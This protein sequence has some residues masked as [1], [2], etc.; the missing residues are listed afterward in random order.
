MSDI[1]DYLNW[2]EAA[3][4][5]TS[6]GIFEDSLKAAGDQSQ[7]PRRKDPLSLYLDAVELE[8]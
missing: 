4:M 2:F 8:F 7:T 1:D 6:S 3:K 5:E